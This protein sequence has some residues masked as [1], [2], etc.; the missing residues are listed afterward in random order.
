MPTY[1]YVCERGHETEV[2]QPIKADALTQCPKEVGATD[3]GVH[4][5]H[6][7]CKRQISECTF[8]LKG[9]GWTGK[10]GA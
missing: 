5:C 2:E 6:A 8:H 10:G 7:P 9:S 1:E 4:H 3:A